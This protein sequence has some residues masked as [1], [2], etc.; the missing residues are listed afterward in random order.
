MTALP[1]KQHLEQPRLRVQ[2]PE[3]R[4]LPPGSSVSSSVVDDMCGH[5]WKWETTP[6]LACNDTKAH[7]YECFILSV[8]MLSI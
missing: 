5:A 3:S 7:S 1:W 2:T 8:W 4:H 6:E